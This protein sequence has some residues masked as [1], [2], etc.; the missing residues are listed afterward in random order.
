[1]SNLKKLLVLATSVVG[2]AAMAQSAVGVGTNGTP[3][4]ANIT[5]TGTVNSAV[6]LTITGAGPTTLTNTTNASN[7]AA[8]GTIDF[9]ANLQTL[10]PNVGAS[11]AAIAQRATLGGNGGAVWAGTVSAKVEF[12]GATNGFINVKAG[13]GTDATFEAASTEPLTSWANFSGGVHQLDATGQE[14]CGAGC[15]S[16][17]APVINLGVFIPDTQSTP[18]TFND[19]VVFT[20]TAS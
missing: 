15:A 1:M 19:V 13:T 9:G 16:G 11:N 14:L 6:T 8:T 2:A 4:T 7:S 10:T 20:A 12:S 3:A 17:D 5:L 18:Y